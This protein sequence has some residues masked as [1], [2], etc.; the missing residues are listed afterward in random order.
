MAEGRTWRECA[1]MVDAPHERPPVNWWILGGGFAFAAV[2]LSVGLLRVPGAEEIVFLISMAI[3]T[4]LMWS[5]LRELEPAARNVLLGTAI[6][7]FV[8][9]AIPGPGA[10]QT[11]WMI[12]DLGFDQRFL[13][14]LGLIGSF[15]TLFG[16]F[17]FRRFMAERSIAYVIGF[18]TVTGTILAAPIIGMFYGLHEWTAAHTGGVV[19]ARFIVLVD[20]ALDS[21]LG[22]IA[23]VPMLAWI[24]NS[25]PDKLKATFFAVMASFT[26]LALSAAQLGTK[27]LNQ[28]FVVT[29]EVKDRASGQVKVPAD[30]SELGVLMIVVTVLGLALPFLAIAIV[31]M[32]R[33]RDA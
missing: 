10:G 3:V 15:L 11:W 26:N 28:A 4:F 30:Y 5:L 22:Q 19:D 29:R 14:V 2:S 17:L 21:P 12:D 16:L 6:I 32:T 8:F 13:A 33:L 20:T 24:A 31:R 7:I 23:M 9:R 25:A 1:S 27:Y 18:L